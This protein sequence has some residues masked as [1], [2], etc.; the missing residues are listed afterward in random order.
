MKTLNLSI[1]K[2]RLQYLK[3][4]KQLIKECKDKGQT[5]AV[6][7]LEWLYGELEREI[8]AGTFEVEKFD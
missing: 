8:E 2:E 1:K 7:S 6:K 5:A 4:L 3:E